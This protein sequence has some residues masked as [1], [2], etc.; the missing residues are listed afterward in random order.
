ML[1][2]FTGNLNFSRLPP[3]G[4][5]NKKPVLDGSVQ[6]KLLPASARRIQDNA[7]LFLKLFPVVSSGRHNRICGAAATAENRFG[8]F[9]YLRTK[10]FR[11]IW[12]S[13]TCPSFR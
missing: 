2:T 13:G 7:V 1:K 8:R 5:L 12:R 11:L 3:G 4:F 9:T 10:L 6:F